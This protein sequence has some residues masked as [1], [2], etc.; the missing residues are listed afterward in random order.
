MPGSFRTTLSASIVMLVV[1]G[2]QIGPAR[3]ANAQAGCAHC[4]SA[5]GK[6]K[7]VKPDKLASCE[8]EREACVR[9]CKRVEEAKVKQ[10]DRSR[11]ANKKAANK[12]KEK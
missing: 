2:L 10:P 3:D 6:C 9:E 4:G 12:K 8:A 1:A 7:R 5:F 11:A